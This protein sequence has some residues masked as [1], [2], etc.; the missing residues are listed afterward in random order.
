MRHRY[1]SSERPAGG[2]PA[3]GRRVARAGSTAVLSW[4][5]R[6]AGS[7]LDA[8]GCRRPDHRCACRGDAPRPHPCRVHAPG[9]RG[10]FPPRNR[11]PAGHQRRCI[12]PA[13]A[14]R[15]ETPAKGSSLMMLHPS[16]HRLSDYAAGDAGLASGRVAAHLVRCR[17]C[18][19]RRSGAVNGT[20][21]ALAGSPSVHYLVAYLCTVR[22]VSD[23]H[24]E[25]TA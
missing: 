6:M 1:F 17:R 8:A 23:L 16:F 11:R 4:P 13:T 14:P 25:F 3:V 7:F 2:C 15:V 19:R 24:R 21:P 12:G 20:S 5:H 10:L 18:R 9:N 22:Q